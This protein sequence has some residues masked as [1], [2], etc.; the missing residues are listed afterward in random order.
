MEVKVNHEPKCV[1][2]HAKGD[3]PVSGFVTFVWAD[4]EIRNCRK[5][6]CTTYRPAPT[7]AEKI[8]AEK[9]R[10]IGDPFGRRKGAI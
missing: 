9:V 8:T 2:G 5:C 4:S 10:A 1:C 6:P 3:H 7:K